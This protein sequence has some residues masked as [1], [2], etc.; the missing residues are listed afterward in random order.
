MVLVPKKQQEDQEIEVLTSME[1]LSNLSESPICI[2]STF[3]YST[4]VTNQLKL[5]ITVEQETFPIILFQYPSN[6]LLS[7]ALSNANIQVTQE[8]HIDGYNYRHMKRDLINWTYCTV[9]T[10]ISCY[11]SK[12]A[13]RYLDCCS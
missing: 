11:I 3:I 9:Q 6:N 13:F 2:S 7:A 10:K 1:L 8:K 12:M 4:A 5:E